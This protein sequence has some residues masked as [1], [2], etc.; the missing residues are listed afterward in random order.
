MFRSSI[1]SCKTAKD[2][3]LVF[4]AVSFWDGLPYLYSSFLVVLNHRAARD[5]PFLFQSANPV[6]SDAFGNPAASRD[7]GTLVPPGLNNMESPFFPGPL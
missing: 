1:Q 3:L 2:L 6:V 7:P 5:R 4:G